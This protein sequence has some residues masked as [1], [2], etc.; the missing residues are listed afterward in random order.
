MYK[1]IYYDRQSNTIYEREVGDQE[2]K[3]YPYVFKYF[4]PDATKQSKIRDC[5]GV[6]MKQVVVNT[7]E[8]MD[9]YRVLRKKMRLAESDLK[10]VVKFVHEKYDKATLTYQEYEDYRIAFY[11]IETQTSRRY[12]M[13]TKIRVRP[14]GSTDE[15]GREITIYEFE[16]TEN[17]RKFQVWDPTRNKWRR[18]YD[19]CFINQ[20][21]PNPEEANYPINLLTVYDTKTE[22]TYTWGLEPYKGNH[23]DVTNYKWF[24]DEFEMMKDFYIWF[25]KQKFDILTG[26]NS[27]KFDDPYII[28]RMRRL[29]TMHGDKHDYT[30]LLSPLKMPVQ[31]R[32]ICDD[33]GKPTGKFHYSAPGLYMIDYLELYKFIGF[34]KN[35]PSWKLDF[36][37]QKEVGEGKVK[38]EYGL[39]EHYIRDYTT[40]VEY[41]VQDVRLMV[42]IEA[43]KR[44]WPTTIAYAN[45]ALIPID[46]VFAM[47]SAHDG[48]IMRFLHAQDQVY[49]DVYEKPVDWW[50]DEG[51]FKKDLGNGI[52]EYQNCTP[53]SPTSFEPYAVK[54]GYCYSD[55]GRYQHNMSGDITSSYPNHIIMYNISPETRVIKPTAEDIASGRVIRSEVN[56]VGFLRTKDAILPCVVEKIFEERLKF[57][58]LMQEAEKAGDKVAADR[59]RTL[60]LTRK[61]LINSLYGACLYNNF[62]LF[63]I[64]C[65]RSITRCARVTI[66][67]LKDNTD[68]YYRSER[69]LRDSME[70]FPV[71]RINGKWYKKADKVM[72]D[73]GEIEAKDITA[74]N[75]IDGRGVKIFVNDTTKHDLLV[76]IKK[77]NTEQVVNIVY[78]GEC[79]IY[80]RGSTV[81]ANF[82][83]NDVTF[84]VDVE[85]GGARFILADGRKITGFDFARSCTID[86]IKIDNVNV[87]ENALTS[88]PRASVVVQV[89]T[90]SNYYCFD[91]HKIGLFPYMDDMEWFY[92]MEKMMNWFW[93]EIL[94][95][96]AAK[97][98]MTNRIIFTRENMFSH[99]ISYAKKLY[100][101]AVVDKDG[102]FFGYEEDP[103][104]HLKIQGL[105]LKKAEFPP[106]C[107]KYAVS[108]TADVLLGSTKEDI[109]KKIQDAYLLFKKAPVEDIST[110]RSV[111]DR[112]KYME[113][114]TDW[115]VEHGSLDLPSGTHQAVKIAEIFNYVIAKEKLPYDPLQRGSKAKFL[116]LHPRN[117]YG[118]DIIGFEQWPK[119]F[120]DIFEINYDLTFEKFFM[121]NFHSLFV[122]VGWAD[123]KKDYIEYKMTSA[124]KRFLIR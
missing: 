69:I 11:D 100:L 45:E 51:Y 35:S 98:Q 12:P 17:C 15:T 113:H 47:T 99:F 57:K 8:E 56:G 79:H 118:F 22:Q 108:I 36:I 65:A 116:F 1:N 106:F 20:E 74:A 33:S 92:C 24:E 117:K 80:K 10:P 88:K 101:G 6:P 21:F 19:S 105:I 28:N 29:Q 40:Y 16:H 52:I 119:E 115:Y 89:D 124:K 123:D 104:K 34:V 94:D 68:K 71:I 64:D 76:P 81:T 66:R 75:T 114:E 38:L 44:L 32:P 41:N 3:K 49:N 27:E 67:Y 87:I 96:K 77:I 70:F 84:K 120:N 13:K 58:L 72:T 111:G 83:G 4:M 73:Q 85:D 122:V 37:G 90:D 82:E 61:K 50:H 48:Y 53:E 93:K 31:S 5:F 91:E 7:K 26:W 9:M 78:M 102:K 30:R 97:N 60:Q 54:A 23:P 112:N 2:Y 39:S 46:S 62:H 63:N 109:T 95:E 43:K 107:Q 103:K 25:W 86:G 121:A 55:P 14:L 110:S 18:Y 59:Y 42:K